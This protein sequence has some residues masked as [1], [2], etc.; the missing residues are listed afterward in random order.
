MKNSRW[1][2]YFSSSVVLCAL[3]FAFTINKVFF[4]QK[5]F[6]N[7]VYV[8]GSTSHDLNRG[9][10]ASQNNGGLLPPSPDRC[11]GYIERWNKHKSYFHE[12]YN[13]PE[14]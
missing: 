1:A 2:L 13:Y 11:K 12:K 3:I 4:K 14:E 9:Q 6:K 5:E 8:T 7:N 10:H